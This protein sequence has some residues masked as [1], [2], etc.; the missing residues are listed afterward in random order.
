MEQTSAPKVSVLMAVKDGEKYLREAVDSILS[1]TFSNFEFII[2]DDG[3]QD[4]SAPLLA[5]Y[6]DPR[7]VLLKNQTSIGLTKSLNLGLEKARGEYIARMDA[8]DISLPERLAVQVNYLNEHLEVD[9][10]GTAV[11]LIDDQK[12]PSLD[13]FFP[14]EYDLIKWHLCFS[15]PIVHSSSMMRHS[16]VLRHHGYD[17]SIPCSQDYDLW[18]RIS[19]DGKLENLDQILVLLRKHSLQVTNLNRNE[20]FEMGL[21]IVQKHVSRKA[22][23][24]IPMSIFRGLWS[25]NYKTAGDAAKLVNFILSYMRV[26]INNLEKESNQKEIEH[27]AFR[28]AKVILSS[29]PK[30]PVI[31][32]A[33]L[34]L[35]WLEHGADFWKL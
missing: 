11:T 27:D 19:S 17:A 30:K 4:G 2:V 34:N 21:N 18:W 29:F 25:K 1:Q 22:G 16:A 33:H 10:L 26:T 8:D 28:R 31:W 7:I 32:Y 23:R 15:N 20:Q 6:S 14:K 3:S 24:V 12:N 9:V 5:E 13:I 35:Y